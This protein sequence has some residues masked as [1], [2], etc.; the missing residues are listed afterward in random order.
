LCA[1]S[2]AKALHFRLVGLR[3]TSNFPADWPAK[4]P[5]R[6]K[7]ISTDSK[8]HA[9]L[10]HVN[11]EDSSNLAS[12][13]TSARI[14]F[15]FDDECHRLMRALPDNHACREVILLGIDIFQHIYASLLPFGFIFIR[16][17]CCIRID[18]SD[19]VISKAFAVYLARNEKWQKPLYEI[20][21]T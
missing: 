11:D 5:T 14:I 18:T 17:L 10:L 3:S 9:C 15:I 2:S 1:D 6:S 12:G 4:R 16:T 19:N 21:R 13:R 7:S 20:A 8:R